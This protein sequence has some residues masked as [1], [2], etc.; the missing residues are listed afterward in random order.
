MNENSIVPI[1]KMRYLLE[2]C[3]KNRITLPDKAIM[4][5]LTAKISSKQHDDVKKL[6]IIK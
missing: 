1:K 6:I 4:G 3:K 5:G 2:T